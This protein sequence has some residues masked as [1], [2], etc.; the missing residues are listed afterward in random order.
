MDGSPAGRQ[1]DPWRTCA[2]RPWETGS[3]GRRV[4]IWSPGEPLSQCKEASVSQLIFIEPESRG[5]KVEGTEQPETSYPAS[6][7]SEEETKGQRVVSLAQAVSSPDTPKSS[8]TYFCLLVSPTFFLKINRC[9]CSTL[10]LSWKLHWSLSALWTQRAPGTLSCAPP[11]VLSHHCCHQHI[12]TIVIKK[13]PPEAPHRQFFMKTY[14]W[15]T[16]T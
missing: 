9:S 14:T 1:E 13:P 7:P 10:G 4:G 15:P 8:L 12:T 3:R 16:G 2:L 11:T 5:H 6:P